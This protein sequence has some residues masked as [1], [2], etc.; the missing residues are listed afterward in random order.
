MPSREPLLPYLAIALAAARAFGL[1]ILDRV[2][3]DI[4]DVD[5]LER[6]CL[7]GRAMGFDGRTLIHPS[8]IARCNQAYSPAEHEVREARAILE[9]FKRP[10]TRETVAI[11]DAIAQSHRS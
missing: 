1:C 9:A 4:Q 6:T 5:A 3:N 11:V 10:E 2:H 7:Q 8:R